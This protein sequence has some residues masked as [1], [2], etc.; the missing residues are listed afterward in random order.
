MALLTDILVW[1]TVSLLPWQRD[2]L[3]RLFQKQTLDSQDMDDLYAML[4]AGHRIP[5]TKNRQ[6]KPLDQQHLPTQQIT[7]T[8]VL[9]LAMRDLKNVNR[10]APNQKLDFSP[11][12]LT[13]IYGGNASG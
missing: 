1:S 10:I 11:S 7:A 12:G 2:A 8:P 13:V 6:P 4:K 3:R 9:L 5:D